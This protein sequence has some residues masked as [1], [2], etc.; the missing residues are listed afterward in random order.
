MRSAAARTGLA[1]ALV[2]AV[3]LLTAFALGPCG[4][5]G[6]EAEPGHTE[7]A[8]GVR[9]PDAS[10]RSAASRARRGAT[11]GAREDETTAARGDP[12]PENSPPADEIPEPGPDELVIRALHAE[13]GTPIARLPVGIGWRDFATWAPTDERGVWR[14]KRPPEEARIWAGVDQ[15]VDGKW[16]LASET[17]VPAG[18]ARTDF[19]VTEADLVEGT[20]VG[21]DGAAVAGVEIDSVVDGVSVFRGHADAEGRWTMR[22]PRGRAAD[23]V[24]TGHAWSG[25]GGLGIR[26]I[27][28]WEGRRVRARRSDVA[29]TIEAR[30]DPQDAKLVVRVLDPDGVA[31]SGAP[32]LVER[33]GIFHPERLTGPDGIVRFSDLLHR[34]LALYAAEPADPAPLPRDWLPM[35]MAFAVPEGQEVTIAFRR[36]VPITGT[37]VTPDGAAVPAAGVVAET[38]P[39]R[40]VSVPKATDDFGRF[41]LV[42][43]PEAPEVL[44]LVAVATRWPGRAP[45]RSDEVRVVLDGVA[46][47]AQ[48]VR[49]VVPR[50]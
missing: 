7:S 18:T 32:V 30:R 28:P 36:G 39:G 49:L 15:A 31:V 19:L 22:T 6:G 23:L 43:P 5:D 13:D 25:G 41:R 8:Q 42:V 46:P 45:G 20:V 27:A 2:A 48:G 37:L 14:T 47:G 4:E 29:P 16:Y 26:L 50:E 21:P 1:G 10:R 35:E 11:A 17:R 33:P 38:V 9:D 3:V 34:R 40:P 44:R 24:L 12:A